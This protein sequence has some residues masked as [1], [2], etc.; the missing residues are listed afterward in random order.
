MVRLR[1]RTRIE[2]R[3]CADRIGAMR[4]FTSGAGARA[5][6][7]V[8]AVAGALLCFPATR[9]D[10]GTYVVYGCKTQSA[11]Q[12]GGAGV[13]SFT[14]RDSTANRYKPCTPGVATSPIELD[15]DPTRP[16]SADA[17]MRLTFIA[18]VDTEIRDFK[19]WRSV[20]LAPG[21]NSRL[22]ELKRSGGYNEMDK[23]YSSSNC[24]EKGSF[25]NWQDNRNEVSGWNRTDL[26]GLEI[27]LTC[28]NADAGATPCPSGSPAA[29]YQLHRSDIRLVDNY[30]PVISA[31]SGSLTSGA[32]VGGVQSVSFS[33]SDRGGGVHE[34]WL[35]VD[36]VSLPR[37]TVD[38]NGG[39]C[40]RPWTAAQPCKPS[41]SGTL[42]LDTRTLKDGEHDVKI[43]ASDVTGTN[44]AGHG[45]F[46]VKVKNSGAG[47]PPLGGTPACNPNPPA[48]S[49]KMAARF[50][51]R[52]AKGKLTATITTT[53]N[54]KHKIQGRLTTPSG[55]PVLRAQICVLVREEAPGAVPSD[56]GNVT[57]D[58]TGAFAYEL[59][60]GVSRAVTFVYPTAAGAVTAT[61]RARVRAPVRFRSSRRAVRGGSAVILSGALR[62]RPRRGLRVEL[63]AHDGKRWRTFAS[64]AMKA[65]GAFR[66]RY[67][68]SRRAGARY[69]K[70]RARV[71]AQLGLPFTTGSSPAARITVRG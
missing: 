32:E 71:P 62:A 38:P 39:L 30:E 34:A 35:V 57:T 22:L 56:G 48:G 24:T 26:R 3:S 9:A 29:L 37:A 60:P 69:F 27:K 12:A 15:M 70:L 50:T 16:H 4:P 8:I 64:T 67:R 14:Q 7:L 46:K 25:S 42:S 49:L 51:P 59:P 58:P 40:A 68:F 28:G 11:G 31:V 36:G 33:A 65:N 1:S 53:F 52:K 43:L 2:G 18:P 5:T 20:A 17:E 55:E 66:Y 45:P 10:A 21:Y 54:R 6:R 19:L 41:A 23:C 63:Q 44:I 47:A 13:W 61:A